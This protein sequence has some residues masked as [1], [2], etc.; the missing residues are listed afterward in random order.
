[1][2]CIGWQEGR[3]W[4]LDQTALP[5]SCVKLE[6][7]APSD[8]AAAIRMMKIRGAPAIGVAAA[9][10]LA[11]TAYHSTASNREDFLR[12]LRET[13]QLLRGTR[14]TAVN[15]FWAI[16]RMLAVAEGERNLES[17]RNLLISTAIRIQDEDEERCR[18]IGEGG[19]ALIPDGVGV[20]THCNTG[21]LA[22]GGFGTALGVILTAHSKGKRIHVYVDETRPALQGA[23]LTAWELKGA[24]IPM[25]LISDNMAGHF[26]KEK[27]VQLVIVGADRIALNGDTAN[28][29]GTYSLSVLAG[30]HGIPFYVAAPSSTI[31]FRISSGDS[32]PI[33]ERSPKEVV[34]IGG[35]RIAPEDIPVANPAF[36]VTPAE[37][38]TAIITEE[39]IHYPP[40]AKSLS[41]VAANA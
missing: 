29:I 35:I 10:G 20:L 13:S 11:L 19:S 14:P 28:K 31:D 41:G 36:D 17:M 16:D 21:A 40:F 33:E 23:R 5:L 4:L 30:A 27:K 37:N 6:Y 12:E 8:L 1:M 15:L 24:G 7:S 22:T 2:R 34:E 32:I 25:T 39:G 38:I 26:M 18:R 9:Y 3:V